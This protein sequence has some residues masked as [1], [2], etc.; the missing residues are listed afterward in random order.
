MS[1]LKHQSKGFTLIELVIV[2]AIAA[3]IIAAILLAVG[4]AQRS[5]RDSARKSLAGRLSSSVQNYAS[6]HNGDL[7]GYTC[8]AATYCNGIVDPDTNAAPVG[9]TSATAAS[10][11]RWVLGNVCSGASGTPGTGTVAGN[12]RNYAITYWTENGAQSICIDNR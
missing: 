10:G 4:G 7:T 9:G 8:T 3:L 6:N 12:A 2:L 5:Q 11:V 1:K